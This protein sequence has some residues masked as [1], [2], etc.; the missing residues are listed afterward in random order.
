MPFSVN[1]TKV[2]TTFTEGGIWP[3]GNMFRGQDKRWHRLVLLLSMISIT[4][5]A[6]LSLV[7]FT[8]LYSFVALIK[9]QV[10][11]FFA[12]WYAFT[13]KGTPAEIEF[14]LSGTVS[15]SRAT[16]IPSIQD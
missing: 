14:C 5:P 4:P 8:I 16:G 11:M 13:E 10:L 3:T 12:S 9:A 6:L 7:F 2:A 1:R 15:L